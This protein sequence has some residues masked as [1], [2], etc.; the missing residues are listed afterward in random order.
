VT[1]MGP[2]WLAST[3]EAALRSRPR[4]VEGKRVV[5]L[6]CP[7]FHVFPSQVSTD[8]AQRPRPH[9]N[10]RQRKSAR[11]QHGSAWARSER[12]SPSR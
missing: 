11:S 9:Q 5:A 3:R 1:C 12:T 6:V 8:P 4:A 2:S 10:G 7:R